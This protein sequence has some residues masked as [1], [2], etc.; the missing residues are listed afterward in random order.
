M[1][2]AMRKIVAP[3]LPP[4]DETPVYHS[5]FGGLWTDRRDAETMLAQ[6]RRAGEINFLVARKLRFWMKHG[7]VILRNAVPHEW[8]DELM[9]DIDGAWER[10]DPRYKVQTDHD[11]YIPLAEADRSSPK[12]KLLDVYAYSEAA[13]QIMFAPK[14]EYFLRTVFERDVLCFQNL[15]FEMG[16]TQGIH[17]DTAYVV[18]SKPMELAASWVALEDVKP[19]SGELRYYPGSHRYPDFN[20][21]DETRKHWDVNI[22]GVD[23]H[24]AFIKS[25]HDNAK[26]MGLELDHFRP[27]K[28]DALI[29]SADLAHGGAPITNPALTRRSYVSHYCPNDVDP[30]YFSFLEQRRTKREVRPGCY[31]SS[32][33]YDL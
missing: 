32:S 16:S 30:H 5:K 9:R 18:C 7:Y 4:L 2:S 11:N 22:D 14:I 25:L 21:G 31:Y 28:G 15:T 8:I 26:E 17:Q 29:W 6:K 10:K 3:E 1:L 27:R 12:I 13:R 33:H 24:K 19:G 20:F 23:A